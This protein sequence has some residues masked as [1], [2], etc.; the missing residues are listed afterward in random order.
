MKVLLHSPVLNSIEV[1]RRSKVGPQP[2][3][4]LVCFVCLCV[5]GGGG[6]GLEGGLACGVFGASKQVMHA[7]P[8]AQQH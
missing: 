5:G 4:V 8:S 2:S 3:S 6:W 7:Q 1:T